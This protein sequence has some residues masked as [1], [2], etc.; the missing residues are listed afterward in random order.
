MRRGAA[1]GLLLLLAAVGCGRRTA[2]LPDPASLPQP[3]PDLTQLE[4]TLRAAVQESRRQV[5]ALAARPDADP[6]EVG[7]AFGALG[8]L[9]H[10]YELRAAARVA[11]R[12]AAL[13][14]PDDFRWPYL[15]GLAAFF[16]G[17]FDVAEARLRRALE[18]DPDSLPARLRLAEV[19]RQ[20]NRQEEAAADFR[21]ALELAPDSAPALFG[22]G[23]TEAAS[24]D[25]AAA[26][27]HFERA[28]ALAPEASS[29][30]YPLAQVYRRLGRADDAAAQLALRGREPV[31]VPDP[32]ARQLD[33]LRTLTAFRVVRTLAADPGDIR[34][35]ELMGLTLT[36]LGNTEG[37]LP[38]FEKALAAREAPGSGAAPAEV[39]RLHYLLGGVL[40]FRGRDAEAIPHFVRA[41]ELSPGLDDAALK[42]GN[43]LARGGRLEEAVGVYSRL[44]ARAP[45][46]TGA[47]LKRATALLNLRRIDAARRDLDAL[48]AARPDDPVVRTRIAEAY[49]MEGRLAQAEAS[50]RRAL[51][52]EMSDA[53]RAALR[54]GFGDYLGRHGDVAGAVEQYRQALDLDPGRTATRLDLADALGR[55]GRYGE[56]ATAYRQAIA[57]RPQEEGARLG[58]AAALILDDRLPEARQRLE[59]GVAVLPASSNLAHLLAR[60]LAAAPTAEVRDGERALELSRKVFASVPAGDVAETVAM[61]YAATG[62]YAEAV[63]WED[64]ALGSL[65]GEAARQGERRRRL[66]AAG[67]PW[68]AAAPE[69]LLVERTTAALNPPPPRSAG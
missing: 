49:E 41:L 16:S 38:P 65:D 25:L 18:L 6:A 60:V 42:L 20:Q 15:E 61:A 47:R 37:V 24:G 4:P 1:A 28:L 31:R 13:L 27:T 26:A 44:L 64:R 67:R 17:D 33:D 58:E 56:A 52:L 11:Y 50:F 29:I 57:Q 62:R 12:N 34:P 46:H 30:H 66:Y 53:D 5:E 22:L 36:Q 9:Y 8:Q 48:V 59:E 23:Q 19:E 51:D 39:A 54:R 43:A 10:A 7:E 35:E 68:R 21:R 45:D 55:L 2:E 69:A 14:R 3:E 40:V 63:R 32:L